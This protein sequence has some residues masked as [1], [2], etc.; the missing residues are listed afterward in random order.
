MTPIFVVAEMIWPM[1][2]P[3][4]VETS[5]QKVDPLIEIY[6]VVYYCIYTVAPLSTKALRSIDDYLANL[7]YLELKMHLKTTAT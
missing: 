3:S 6:L 4:F 1:I 7:L 5:C 2:W